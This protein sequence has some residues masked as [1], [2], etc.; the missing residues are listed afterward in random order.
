LREGRKI[1]ERD[2]PAAARSADGRNG[3][4]AGTACQA[5]PQERESP[6]GSDPRLD[7]GTRGG[8]NAR[9]MMVLE[10]QLAILLLT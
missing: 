1:L 8:D 2:F 5:G 6:G 3:T 7:I 9:H 4:G 10:L